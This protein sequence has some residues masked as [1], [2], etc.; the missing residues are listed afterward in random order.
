MRTTL[1]IAALCLV[2][3]FTVAS[4]TNKR[5]TVAVQAPAQSDPRVREASLAQQKMCDEQANK[6]FHEDNPHPTEMDFYTSHY[7]P[8]TNVCYMRV[9]SS[10]TKYIS[11]SVAIYDAFEGRE[12]AFYMWINS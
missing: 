1:T 10:S 12:Y 9:S 8:K 2:V 6:K 3:G 4:L 11:T 7:D 5:E